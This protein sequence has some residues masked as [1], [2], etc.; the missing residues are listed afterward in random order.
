MAGIG[1]ILVPLDGSVLAEHAIPLAVGVAAQHNATVRLV[2]VDIPQ[3]AAYVAGI[4]AYEVMEYEASGLELARKRA[5]V[6]SGPTP[7]IVT[8]L[9]RGPVTEAL[10]GYAEDNQV[11]LVVMTTRGHPAL[12]RKWIGDI[13]DDIVRRAPVP[14][15]L[16]RP[17][18]EEADR[19][20]PRT[21][22]RVL[23]ALD[24][25]RAAE[26]I[27]EHAVAVGGRKARYEL[28]QVADTP[29]ALPVEVIDL[30]LNDQDRGTLAYLGKLADHLR[31]KGFHASP[32]LVAG[33]GAAWGISDYACRS[34]ADLIAMTTRGHGGRVGTFVGR[35]AESVVRTAPVPVLLHGPGG[36]GGGEHGPR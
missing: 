12:V 15:V 36:A 34:R 1:N 3:P 31:K 24:G 18:D 29:G 30:P 4:P 33:D 2:T 7:P 10:L 27:L 8:A 14:V 23:V 9:I 28:M 19:R 21:I 32:R 35:V 22:E 17:R 25:S 11:D 20:E 6:G 5:R 26:A 13:E 16:D